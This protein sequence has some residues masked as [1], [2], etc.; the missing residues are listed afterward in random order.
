MRQGS[1]LNLE[2]VIV[3]CLD[4][5]H[6]RAGCIH[7]KEYLCRPK[8]ISVVIILQSQLHSGRNASG[9]ITMRPLSSTVEYLGMKTVLLAAN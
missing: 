2:N 4:E 1:R 9:D 8:H 3:I 6:L 7:L 5:M